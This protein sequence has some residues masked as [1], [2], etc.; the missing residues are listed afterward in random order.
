MQILIFIQWVTDENFCIFYLFFKTFISIKILPISNFFVQVENNYN[1]KYRQ[2][3]AE[4]L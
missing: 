3:L 1:I 2:K 4:T